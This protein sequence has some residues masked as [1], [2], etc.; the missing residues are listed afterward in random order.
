SS[1][2]PRRPPTAQGS[3]DAEP[4]ALGHRCKGGG[5]PCAL[6]TVHSVSE[7]RRTLKVA[8][9]VD[10]TEARNDAGFDHAVGGTEPGTNSGR[11]PSMSRPRLPSGAAEPIWMVR[12][13]PRCAPW[14]LQKPRPA[15]FR[16][17]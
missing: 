3:A 9:F 11:K 12:S 17:G 2:P 16:P 13:Y 10:P 1:Y 5:Q 4:L 15:G 7:G 14:N 6:S 8:T